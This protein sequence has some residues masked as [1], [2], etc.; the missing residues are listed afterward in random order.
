MDDVWKLLITAVSVL[1]AAIAG[2]LIAA[3]A[4]R[5]NAMEAVE[6]DRLNWLRDARL[7][8]YVEFIELV[9]PFDKDRHEGQRDLSKMPGV[10]S[11]IARIE[12][13][14]TTKVREEAAKAKVAMDDLYKKKVDAGHA[15]RQIYVLMAAMRN[16]MNGKY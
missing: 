1:L 9:H 8:A 13:L 12:I 15:V 10:L 6:S 2:N 5:Q 16:E 11:A 3:R 14:G 4:S 7:K